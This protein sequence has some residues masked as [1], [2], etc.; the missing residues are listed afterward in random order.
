MHNTDVFYEVQN[1]VEAYVTFCVYRP[2]SYAKKD[3]TLFQEISVIYK[4]EYAYNTSVILSA[5]CTK[6]FAIV[7]Q[8]SKTIHHHL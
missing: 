8:N 6:T 4:Q 2:P 5:A 7:K 3:T 1:D